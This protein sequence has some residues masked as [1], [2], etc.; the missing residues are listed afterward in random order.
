M[1]LLEKALK[2]RESK[3]EVV[4]EDVPEEKKLKKSPVRRNVSKPTKFVVPKHI[5]TLFN[6]LDKSISSAW[7][8]QSNGKVKWDSKYNQWIAFKEWF[9]ELM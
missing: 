2:A 7:G 4:L 9:E 6:N 1:S 5:K 3:E 8:V